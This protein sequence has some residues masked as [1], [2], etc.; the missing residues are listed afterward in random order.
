V[1]IGNLSENFLYNRLPEAR[2]KEDEQG[3]IC[4]VLGGFQDRLEDVRSYAKKL[5][6]FWVPGA[7]PDGPNNAVLVDLTSNPGKSYTRSLDIQGDTPASDPQLTLW[8]A[9][10]LGLNIEDISNVRYGRDLLRNVDSSLLGYLA[11]T[12]GAVI[13]QSLVLSDSQQQAAA[14]D[15]VSTWF[16][17]LKIKGT[18]QSFEVLGRILGFDDVRV[19]PLWTRLSPRKPDDIGNSANDPDFAASGDYYPAQAISSFYNPFAF[20]DGPFFSWD[21]VVNNGTADTSYYT[22]AI[23]GFNPWVEVIL[24][25]SLAGTNV[26]AINQG[27]ATHPSTGTYALANGSP[28]FKAYV[29][30]SGSSVRFQALAEGDDFNGLI[31]SATTSGSLCTIGI[32]DRLSAVK[33]RSSYFDIG[34]AADMDKLEEIF[35][36]RAATANKDLQANPTLTSDG[37]AASPF[38]PWVGG[39]I[40]VQQTRADW[41]TSSGSI[42]GVTT[43]RAE[44][45]PTKN[46]QLNIDA[47]VAAGV[48]VIQAFEE[49]RPATRL[50]RRSQIGFLTDDS[51]HYAAN[52]RISPLFS[53]GTASVYSGTAS[54][55]P[56]PS[57]VAAIQVVGTGTESMAGELDASGTLLSFQDGIGFSGSY[58]LSNAHYRFSFAGTTP[59]NTTIYAL[60]TPTTT[61]VVRPEPAGTS[62]KAYQVR[63]ENDTIGELVYEVADDFGWRRDIVGGGEL[64]ELDT[65]WAGTELGIEELEEATAFSDQTG[66]DISV[67]GINSTART[68]RVVSAP[69]PTDT[70]YK[71]AGPAIGYQGT[72]KSLTKLTGN[73]TALPKPSTGTSVGDTLTDYD[74]L[75]EPGYK[76]FHTGLAQGVLVADL[77]KFFGQQH[78][79]GLVLWLPCNEHPEDALLV[80][81]HSVKNSTQALY[82]LNFGSRVWDDTHGWVLRLDTA[83]VYTDYFRD[84]TTAASAS[85][86][87]KMDVQPGVEDSMVQVGPLIFKAAAGFVKGYVLDV[88][89][90]LVQ[91][92]SVAISGDWQFVYLRA[93]DTSAVFGAG[94]L[95]SSATES[96]VNGAFLPDDDDDNVLVSAMEAKFWLHDLRGWNMTKT[97]A[98]MDLVRYHSPTPTIALYRLGFIKTLD[99]QDKYGIRVLANGWAV[100]D[101]LPSWYRRT[102]QGLV[103]RYDSMGSYHGESRFKETGIGDA[104]ILP[105]LYQLGQ[106]FTSLTASGTSPFSTNS[107]QLPGQNQFWATTVGAG[108]LAPAN[109]TQTNPFREALW[110]YSGSTNTIYELTLNGSGASTYLVSAEVV[111]GRSV[112]EVTADPFLAA[113]V[114]E[115]TV[116]SSF[117]TFTVTGTVLGDSG[118]LRSFDPTLA[119]THTKIFNLKDLY[120]SEMP[121]GARGVNLDLI[122]SGTSGGSPTAYYLYL[123]SRVNVHASDAYQTWTDAG[124]ITAQTNGVDYSPDPSIV[125]STGSG[126]YL[127]APVIG[128]NGLLEFQNN[129]TLVPGNYRLTI[130]SGN[131]GLLDEDFD[132]FMV[133][134]KVNSTIL[135]R[136]LLAGF[137]GYNVRGTDQFEFE[138]ADSVSG[139]W[140]LSV[141]WFNALK[142]SSRGTQRQL[143]IFSYTL[144]RIATEAFR[145]DV[146]PTP[147][148][149]LITK[150]DLTN[151]TSGTTPGGWYAT[152][153]SY[154]TI[155][156]REHEALIYPS[157]D[158]VTSKSPLSDLL[159][160]LT[161]ERR[162]DSYVSGVVGSEVLSDPGSFT[163]PTFSGSVSVSP[164]KALYQTGDTGT[165]SVN[166]A[167][168]GTVIYSYVWDFWDATTVA[169]TGSSVVKAIN[170][171]GNPHDNDKL[172]VSCTPVAIDG[173]FTTLQGTIVANNPP[174]IAPGVF[175]TNN[176]SYF[177]YTTRL[178]LD[179][180][181][182]E[183]D[184]LFFSW[185]AGSHFL[186]HGTTTK[187]L[188]STS[189]TWQGNDATVVVT[190]AGTSN[191]FDTLVLG[192]EGLTCVVSD[193]RS[194]T[195]S[196]DFDL[197]GRIAPTPLAS[198][199]A[200]V[201]NILV[202]T[203]IVPSQ[204][205][206]TGE[207]VQ[208]TVYASDPAGGTLSFA[209][210]FAGSNNW[211][212][213]PILDAGT[214]TVL[215]DGTVQNT[216]LRDIS[217]E[218]IVS[219]TAKLVTA[220]CDVSSVDPVSGHRRFN[221][222]DIE[223]TLIG[224]SPPN[225]LA[226]MRTVGG[227]EIT[228]DGPVTAG[229]NITFSLSG[230]DPNGDAMT[231]QWSFA[232]PFTPATGVYWG[233]K[234]VYATSRYSSGDAVQGILTITDRL[235]AATTEGIPL[236]QIQ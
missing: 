147:A 136:K 16:P 49:V 9:K 180:F 4:A 132:G 27:T 122:S 188:V 21:T 235:G 106:Q 134:L 137:H 196:L 158:T 189:G 43:A 42:T 234:I 216:V 78:R 184:Q 76:L 166:P 73:D 96:T 46:R 1:A 109:L 91:I 129:S 26:P 5:S 164:Y 183:N 6:D 226:I 93:S 45:D 228:D 79:D 154:G 126:A 17:R 128:K 135:E 223:V 90:L 186:S 124:Q 227:T 211:N 117:G 165:F 224:N 146:Y 119:A 58:D 219:G 99:R 152:I 8:A 68:I 52:L 193:A 62:D 174:S 209:W 232:Q 114:Q 80:R 48:Q 89:S 160:G 54:G 11:T 176:D 7:L 23:N 204:R 53:T 120:V 202:D 39:S 157:N 215:P 38:R 70:T 103:L 178:G 61:E 169:T 172:V 2:I 28:N 34:L 185:Y 72:I 198:L 31:V 159:T 155:I 104:R 88:N 236:T 15:L 75:F 217:S 83:N 208:F 141:E 13:Y 179:A 201:T 18:T 138:L 95:G 50:P 162:D 150:L 156:G 192:P 200:G 113:L 181:D 218:V 197:R 145:V 94:T 230:S 107:G 130:E 20:R 47:V 153:D 108:S 173:Q 19:T 66:A 151:Y 116:N 111:R 60:W 64:V 41:V 168:S 121:T 213:S 214:T 140:L 131:L 190:C 24:L 206:G 199:S 222:V 55:Y 51:A 221:E 29:E 37:T 205:I 207:T 33:Y 102:R 110:A 182:L 105:S 32:D 149:P 167:S 63:P 100:P 22:Q 97:K 77:P 225:E 98:Q 59:S 115:G 163:Y 112:A 69:R 148:A 65:Y 139:N 71:P 57:Y 44:A 56:L 175:I 118:T 195:T 220:I 210:I 85:F 67:Y 143:A 81:D 170:I 171:G 212:M 40:A 10:Q 203:A 161:A 74:T 3:L 101:V 125:Q 231:Y 229:Q 194:G 92:G 25:G 142:D 12:I 82:N 177:A 35:G 86:W 87:F 191:Y 187:D 144:S 14:I 133:E 123:N 233:P 84:F 30:P 127:L 36:S